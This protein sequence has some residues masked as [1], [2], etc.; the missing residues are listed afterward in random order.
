MIYNHKLRI[1]LHV[2]HYIVN[3]FCFENGF[4]LALVQ[5]ND[6][7]VNTFLF[8]ITNFTLLCLIF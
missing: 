6:Q 2:Y 3:I 7:A 8:D 4:I 5:K 1:L